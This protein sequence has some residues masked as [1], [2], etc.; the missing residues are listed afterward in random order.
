MSASRVLLEK[1]IVT[2]LAK[3]YLLWN[4]KVHYCVHNS[5]KL[6][7]IPSHMH[8]VHNHVSHLF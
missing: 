8:P 7:P 1:L 2:Q 6:V 5:P 4:A 3:R